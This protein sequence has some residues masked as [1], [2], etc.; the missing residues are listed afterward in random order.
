VLAAE[1]KPFTLLSSSA[2]ISCPQV[3][4]YAKVFWERYT[5]INDHE[6]VGG[7]DVG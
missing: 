3:R 4:A 7:R 5:E 6:K 2:C 1:S